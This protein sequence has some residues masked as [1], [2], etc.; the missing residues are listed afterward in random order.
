MKPGIESG[1]VIIILQQKEHGTFKRSGNDLYLEKDITLSE[2]LCGFDMVLTH[3]D[4]RQIKIHCPPRQVIEPGKHSEW[5]VLFSWTLNA[6]VV[7]IM[8]ILGYWLHQAKY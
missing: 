4:K 2:A 3:L 5:V 6:Y 7:L 8:N 1:D